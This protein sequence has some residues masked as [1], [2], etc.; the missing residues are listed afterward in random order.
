MTSD[1]F[2]RDSLWNRTLSW[3]TENPNLTS[4]LRNTL[5]PG[6]PCAILWIATS[7]WFNHMTKHIPKLVPK[8]KEKVVTL[9]DRLTFLF[10]SKFI[11]TLLLLVNVICEL[12]LRVQ[13]SDIVYSSDIFYSSILSATFALVLVLLCYEKK[14]FFRTSPPL[15][16][17]FTLLMLAS[18]PTFKVDVEEW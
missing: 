18:V 4:C 2:C 15:S 12:V 10:C 7:F 16:T 3:D 9:S 5:L 14:H 13:N 8:V 17:F 6:I 1:S 11:L